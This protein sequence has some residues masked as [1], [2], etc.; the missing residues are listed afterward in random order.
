[1]SRMIRWGWMP[2]AFLLLSTMAE[3]SAVYTITDLGTL[4]GTTLSFATGIN[5]LGQVVGHSDGATGSQSFLY[6]NGQ[7]TAINDPVSGAPA[8]GINNSG[9]VVSE[10]QFINNSGQVVS[11]SQPFPISI[12]T[13]VNGVTTSVQTTFTPAGI[14]DAGQILGSIVNPSNPFLQ[15]NIGIYQNGKFLDISKALGLTSDTTTPLAINNVGSVLFSDFHPKTDTTTYVI[16][17]A[18][19]TSQTLSLGGPETAMN[20][21]GQVVGSGQVSTNGTGV[22]YSNGSYSNL[23]SLLPSSSQTLWQFL[24]PSAINNEGQIVGA[25]EIDGQVHAFLMTPTTTP[26]PSTLALLITALVSYSVRGW[27]RNRRRR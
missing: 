21:A 26:E 10:G 22:L 3:A 6:S 16:Y 20:S 8:G 19:G 15:E 13:T 17:K 12:S 24:D 27:R 11:G 7:M 2:A 9:Q 25:G 18:D 5:D 23:A 4:P 1:M 14:N